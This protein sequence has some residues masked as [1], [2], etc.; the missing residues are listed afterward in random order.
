MP[1]TSLTSHHLQYAI[2]WYALALV[3]AAIYLIYHLRREES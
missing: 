3:L 1:A 2:T